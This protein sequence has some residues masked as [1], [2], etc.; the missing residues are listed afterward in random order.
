MIRRGWQSRSQ[1]GFA[2]LLLGMLPFLLV[3][4]YEA[5][6]Q[7]IALPYGG[8]P[9]SRA[10]VLRGL[11]RELPAALSWAFIG[12]LP[13]EPLPSRFGSW[14]SVRADE[15]DFRWMLSISEYD[16]EQQQSDSNE[17]QA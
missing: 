3:S 8:V 4:C 6:F 17:T 12:E 1:Y 11:L 2:G 10:T 5:A 13:A 15:R 14:Q 9:V 7:L 16:H